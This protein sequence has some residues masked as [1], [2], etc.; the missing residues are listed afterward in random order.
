MTTVLRGH[1]L[2]PDISLYLEDRADVLFVSG[3]P[4]FVTPLLSGCVLPPLLSIL[5]PGEATPHLVLASLRTLNTIADSLSLTD[6]SSTSIDQSLSSLLFSAPY[7]SALTQI[8]WQSNASSTVQQQITLAANL[9]AKS[10]QEEWHRVAL[11]DSGAL[12]ALSLRLASFVVSMG[13][14]LPGA[15]VQ[16][17]T[18]DTLDT[19]PPPAPANATL[20]PI[21]EAIG[22]IVQFSKYRATV[23]LR[24]P[25]ILTVFPR[26]S[27]DI[28]STHDRTPS[29]PSLTSSSYL[30]QLVPMNPI[31]YLLPQTPIPHHRGS[32]AHSASFPPLG[33]SIPLSRHARTA[34]ALDWSLESRP[35]DSNAIDDED[36]S[37]LVSWLIYIT[38]T[39]SGLTCLMAVWLLTMLYRSGLTNKRRESSL[40]LLLVPLLVRMLSKDFRSDDD[41][42]LSGNGVSTLQSSTWAIKEQ[43]P[44]VLAMLVMDSAELQKA[45]V[46]ADAIKKLSQLL[47]ES[48]DPLPKAS[49]STMWSPEGAD[50]NQVRGKESTNS[51]RLGLPGL[52]PQASYVIR[53]R[54]GVLIALAA[55]APFKDEYRKAMIDNGVVPFIIESLKPYD[56]STPLSLKSTESSN[57]PRGNPVTVLL[58]ACSAARALS[59]SV[60][61]LRTSLIDAGIAVPLFALLHHPEMEVQIAAT[62]VVCNLVLEFSPMREV[63]STDIGLTTTQKQAVD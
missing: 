20:A 54:E 35:M 50:P 13:L 49:Q 28:P 3:G 19:I 40:A 51:S 10:C 43:A 46:D 31:D 33:A 16:R 57:M 60:S 41:S 5:S 23:L 30:M 24:S 22:T 61:I 4:A 37:A 8:L 36:E 15:E 9:I 56:A 45:A 42:L 59:R 58:A 52:S 14:V 38:R 48:Y 44:K 25:P 53:M 1:A 29:G 27:A 21:L 12:D 63:S 11:E 17:Q 7:I 2:H 6:P 39:T 62:A 34:T 55:I 26:S 47:K 32:S 18:S